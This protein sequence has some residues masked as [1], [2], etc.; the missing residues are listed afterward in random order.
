MTTTTHLHDW[1]KEGPDI[2]AFVFLQ[3]ASFG[4]L[5]RELRCPLQIS[6]F[7]L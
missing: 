7:L 3:E 2:V 6:A 4:M 5:D 1:E